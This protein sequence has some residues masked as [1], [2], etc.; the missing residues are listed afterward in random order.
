MSTSPLV[1]TAIAL[2]VLLSLT[3]ILRRADTVDAALRIVNNARMGIVVLTLV[4]FVVGSWA[5]MTVRVDDW[6]N[7]SLLPF[8]SCR[9]T[10]PRA[11]GCD[12]LT[13]SGR[14]RR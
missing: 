14:D 13:R 2:I 6:S 7:Y 10:S 12:R 9:T 3:R 1:Y 11:D 5:I 4:T 8:P